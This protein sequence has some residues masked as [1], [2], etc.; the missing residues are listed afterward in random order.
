MDINRIDFGNTLWETFILPGL[1][2]A[3]GI[4]INEQHTL[5]STQYKCAKAV[6]KIHCMPDK[7]STIGELGYM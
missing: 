3:A 4:W 2:H 6:L 1:S 5:S 7:M